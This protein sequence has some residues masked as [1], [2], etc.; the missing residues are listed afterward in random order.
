MTHRNDISLAHP[1]TTREGLL[2][3]CEQL[4]ASNQSLMGALSACIYT[5]SNELPAGN[6]AAIEA[7]DLGRRALAQAQGDK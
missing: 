5:L 6:M 3:R 2:N 1:D 4:Y 7:K